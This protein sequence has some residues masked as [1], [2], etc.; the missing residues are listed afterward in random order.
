MLFFFCFCLR[1][2]NHLPGLGSYA[3]WLQRKTGSMLLLF[4]R[5]Q[6]NLLSQPSISMAKT[7]DAT[8]SSLACLLMNVSS[9]S[10]VVTDVVLRKHKVAEWASQST[11][12]ESI[13]ITSLLLCPSSLQEKNNPLASYWIP[14]FF[15]I[16]SRALHYISLTYIC[17]GYSREHN[18]TNTG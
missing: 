10:P 8:L 17:W 1:H 18:L 4:C 11:G 15:L 9:F 6:E 16:V 2:Y 7:N 14:V 13:S 12:W 5:W 3:P